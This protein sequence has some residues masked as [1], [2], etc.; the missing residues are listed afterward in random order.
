M[1]EFYLIYVDSWDAKKQQ[2]VLQALV[3]YIICYKT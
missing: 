1:G 2:Q 3:Y